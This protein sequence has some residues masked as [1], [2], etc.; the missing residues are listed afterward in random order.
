ME[1]LKGTEGLMVISPHPDDVEF[2]C[3]G[4]IA[5]RGLWDRTKVERSNLRY[6]LNKI[7]VI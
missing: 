7:A 5:R 3:S 6:E 4:T 1:N 2:G